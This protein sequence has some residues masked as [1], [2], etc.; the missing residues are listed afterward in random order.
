M[1]QDHQ[2]FEN[3]DDSYDEYQQQEYRED[4]LHFNDQDQQQDYDEGNEQA[5]EDNEEDQQ[6]NDQAKDQRSSKNSDDE[7]QV[8]E[9]TDMLENKENKPESRFTYAQIQKYIESQSYPTGFLKADK[10]ALRKRAKFFKVVDGH[11][12][13]TGGK[14]IFYLATYGLYFCLIIINLLFYLQQRLPVKKQNWWLKVVH[15]E[16]ASFHP[17]MIPPTWGLTVP[18]IWCPKSIIGHVS[19]RMFAPS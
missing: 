11:L 5:F 8:M 17:F 2:D 16:A 1:E 9:D 15:K 4:Q 13:Y 6:Q 12:Y 19:P 10:L 3:Y 7:Q 18:S 14:G